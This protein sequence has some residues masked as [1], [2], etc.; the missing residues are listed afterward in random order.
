MVSRGKRGRDLMLL[1]FARPAWQG[2]DAAWFRRR[3]R[4]LMRG[5]F[6]RQAWQGFDVALFF[7]ATRY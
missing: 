5:G 1:G 6:A 7:V 3:D 2:F 4:D